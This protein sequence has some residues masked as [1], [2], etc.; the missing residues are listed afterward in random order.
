MNDQDS[1][2]CRVYEVHRAGADHVSDLF[3]GL[4]NVEWEALYFY[5]QEQKKA[6]E[7]HLRH[8]EFAKECRDHGVRYGDVA[9]ADDYVFFRALYDVL[10]DVFSVVEG[11]LSRFSEH[12]GLYYGQHNF[13]PCNS[14]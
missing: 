6:R 8:C 5:F 9:A 12:S 13:D 1:L 3:I 14:F 2:E 4:S 7:I 11:A 10:D